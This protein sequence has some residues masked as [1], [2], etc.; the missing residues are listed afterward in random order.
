MKHIIYSILNVA[1]KQAVQN[2]LTSFKNIKNFH[3]FQNKPKATKFS[4]IK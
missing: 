2:P 1:I 3:L 4:I